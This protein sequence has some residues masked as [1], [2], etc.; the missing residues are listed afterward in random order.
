MPGDNLATQAG[1]RLCFCVG[2]SN[3]GQ[4]TLPLGASV[5]S[6]QGRIKNLL[7][8]GLQEFDVILH[9]T[10]P[11]QDLAQ[12]GPPEDLRPPFLPDT[13]PSTGAQMPES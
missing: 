3:L 1:L 11:A 12:G 9:H 10:D 8:T 2:A 13:V 7:V 5:C 6:L 4:V